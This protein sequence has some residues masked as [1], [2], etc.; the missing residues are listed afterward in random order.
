MIDLLARATV[1]LTGLYLFGL[2]VATFIAPQRAGRFLLGFAGSVR[3]HALEL[4]LR[5]LVGLAFLRC[6]HS[7]RFA[8]AFTVCGWTLVLTTTVLA[9]LPWQWHQRFAQRTVPQALRSLWLIGLASLLF[10]GV[11]LFAMLLPTH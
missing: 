3:A 4:V 1:L 10:G 8:D 6:A 9:V 7:M 5:M 2:G 11:I